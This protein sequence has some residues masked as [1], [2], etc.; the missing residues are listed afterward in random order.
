MVEIWR[1]VRNGD[2]IDNP[3]GI[4]A[5]PVM[6]DSRRLRF[7]EGV[8]LVGGAPFSRSDLD[9][10]LSLA[11]R[12]VCADGGADQ[13]PSRTPDAVIGDLDSLSAPDVWRKRLGHRLIRV[14]E[15]DSTDLEKCLRRV[16]APFFIAVGFVAGRVDHLLA[17]LHAIICDQRPVFLVGEED[18]Q[19][20]A[21]FGFRIEARP[22]DRIS[23][24][25]L[26]AVKSFG[27][28]GLRWPLEGLDLEAG[29][30]IATSNQATGGSVSVSFDRPGV[31]V[32]LPR[33]RLDRAVAV[34]RSGPVSAPDETS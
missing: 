27:G 6:N 20:S 10:A 19:I 15:Q 14:E 23:F 34:F 33:D 31:I 16:E 2:G 17:A 11:P 26:R 8:T 21:G 5:H 1:T 13:L 29:G 3:G 28:T 25:P 7:D 18:I 9:M 4:D 30:K 24:F 22:G 12:I 32:S